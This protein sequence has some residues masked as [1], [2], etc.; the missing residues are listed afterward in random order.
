VSGAVPAERSFHSFTSLAPA[1]KQQLVLFGG[2][3]STNALLDDVHVFDIGAAPP[4]FLFEQQC[5]I[6][7]THSRWTT[8]S[9]VRLGAADHRRQ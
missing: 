3:S 2:L 7:L 6:V 5:S 4:P 8:R 1:G 9:Y